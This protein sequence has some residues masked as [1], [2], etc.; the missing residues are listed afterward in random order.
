MEAKQFG[1]T[2]CLTHA[3]SLQGAAVQVEVGLNEYD[4][5]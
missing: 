5:A 4:Y 2:Q 3:I 1:S